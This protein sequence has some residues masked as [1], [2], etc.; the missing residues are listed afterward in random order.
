MHRSQSEET[1][2]EKNLST[3]RLVFSLT[4]EK[5]AGAI[6]LFMKKKLIHKEQNVVEC[7]EFNDSACSE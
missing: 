6:C 4:V 7:N 5:T 1:S 2:R 3:I